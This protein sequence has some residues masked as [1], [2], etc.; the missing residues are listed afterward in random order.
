M[1]V[2]S[3]ILSL[4]LSDGVSPGVITFQNTHKNF[5]QP[6]SHT[7]PHTHTARLAY[8]PSSRNLKKGKHTQKSRLHPTTLS[9]LSLPPSLPLT[10]AHTHT[11]PVYND[12]TKA[13]HTLLQ[14]HAQQTCQ[15]FFWSFTQCKL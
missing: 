3:C 7:T 14:C 15:C 5:H 10:H 8:H 13:D 12:R 6:S 11:H 2:Y 1:L 4:S 9:D